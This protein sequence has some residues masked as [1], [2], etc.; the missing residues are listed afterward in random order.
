MLSK[1]PDRDASDSGQYGLSM[2]KYVSALDTEFGAYFVNY[3]THTPNLGT[4]RDSS[5]IPGSIW[6]S[7]LVYGS[8]FWDYSAE[9]IKIFGLSAS[10]VIGGWAVAGE[11]VH[12]TNIP[13]QINGA[14]LFLM[15]ILN[16]GPVA[17]RNLP[18]QSGN[19]ITGYDRKSKSQINLSTIKSFGNV[20]GASTVNLVGEV[21]F[22][23]WA[24]IGD[25]FTSVR[26]GRDFEYGAGAHAS[27]GGAA[28]C[29]FAGSPINSVAANCS[30]DGYAT[31]NAWGV[32]VQASAEYPNLIPGIVVKPRLF[33][34]QDVKGW[35]A[36]NSFRQ[37]R[38]TVSIGSKFAYEQRYYLDLSYSTF[39]RS[40]HFDNL[41][42]RDFF[43]LVVGAS[44]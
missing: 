8:G 29:G 5:T 17:D 16:I 36:D 1:Q 43:G 27:L 19:V 24:G 10:T 14:D 28:G 35:S 26:Y 32:R 3:H 21:A 9:N 41:N 7:P 42:D 23:H 44:F 31:P 38:R 15:S 6:S 12:S 40:A 37:G 4:L 25:P 39:N 11:V 22:Q 33:V 30:T 20:L 18:L 34:S 13:V 2:K